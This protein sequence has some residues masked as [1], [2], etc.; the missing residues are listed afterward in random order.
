M[1]YVT[2][3]KQKIA[4]LRFTHWVQDAYMKSVSDGIN[5]VKNKNE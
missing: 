3:K 1:S 4:L 5:K 2:V